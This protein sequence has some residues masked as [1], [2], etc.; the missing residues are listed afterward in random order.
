M[1]KVYK[2]WDIGEL[3]EPDDW[4]GKSRLG[5][6]L[7]LKMGTIYKYKGTKKDADDAK[8]SWPPKRVTITV[9]VEE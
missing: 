5:T 2:G 4:E 9:E 3:Y 7:H 6:A 1:K 8:Y